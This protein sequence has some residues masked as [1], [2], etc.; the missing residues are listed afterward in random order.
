MLKFD[1]SKP[2]AQVSNGDFMYIEQGGERFT[3]SEYNNT[4]KLWIPEPRPLNITEMVMLR[5]EPML[6]QIKEQLDKANKLFGDIM[7]GIDALKERSVLKKRGPYK[8]KDKGNGEQNQKP[9]SSGGSD[10]HSSSGSGK[11][12]RPDNKQV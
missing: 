1:Q 11:T 7:S 9:D 4:L 3:N 10:L 8:K 2:A 5:Y 12:Q 6:S